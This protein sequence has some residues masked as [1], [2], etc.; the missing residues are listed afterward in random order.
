M[1]NHYNAIYHL[2]FSHPQ[3]KCVEGIV[4]K[5]DFATTRNMG[6]Y[7]LIFKQSGTDYYLLQTSTVEDQPLVEFDKK[8]VLRF[9]IT[10]NYIELVHRS[11]LPL[12][13]PAGQCCYFRLNAAS[14]ETVAFN[15][16]NLID[17]INDEV[18]ALELFDSATNEKIQPYQ[19]SDTVVYSPLEPKK[20]FAHFSIVNNQC[21]G[22]VDFELQP[23]HKSQK[24]NIELKE[25][26]TYIRYKVFDRLKNFNSFKIESK[27]SSVV[28]SSEKINE[29]AFELS[30][31][32]MHTY[33]EI[34]DKGLS[35]I[36]IRNNGRSVVIKEKLS[37]P[38]IQNLEEDTNTKN[39]FLSAFIYI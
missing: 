22:F 23:G 10:F 18:L 8:M 21:S 1:I 34:S 30:S 19:L 39:I 25:R 35:L 38:N 11:D 27:N 20:F 16:N 2:T 24:I 7:R 31:E 12:Y 13:N 29:Q 17:K 3:S 4:L 15:S 14:G 32:E 33:T 36:G 5:P 9:F 6:R 26:K 37:V 28:F